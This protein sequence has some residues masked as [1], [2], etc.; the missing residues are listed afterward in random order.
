[1]LLNMELIMMKTMMATMIIIMTTRE[2]IKVRKLTLL[3]P[4]R[5]FR[6]PNNFAAFGYP[7]TVKYIEMFYAD[8]SYLSNY[9]QNIPKKHFFLFRM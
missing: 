8:F 7:L 4:G 2:T 3:L 5:V 1:M 9:Y 6:T